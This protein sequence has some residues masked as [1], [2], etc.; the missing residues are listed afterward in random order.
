MNGN[1][2][3]ILMH[4]KTQEIRILRPSEATALIKVIPKGYHGTMFKALLYTGMR[5]TELQVFKEHREWFDGSFIKVPSTKCGV[6]LNERWVRLNPVGKSVIS[7]YLKLKE[8]LPTLISWRYNLKRWSVL[9]GL[10]PVGMMPKVTRKTW[11]SWLLHYYGQP[12]FYDIVQSQGHTVTTSLE[13][14]VKLPFEPVDK[15]Q[16]EEYV[17]GWI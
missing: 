16:M 3:P 5:Y 1:Y 6:R 17:G 13:H 7:D 2:N 15:Q 11:E 9:A 14:Y 4:T 10:D 12:K 8:C